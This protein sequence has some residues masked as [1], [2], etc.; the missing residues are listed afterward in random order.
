MIVRVM[1]MERMGGGGGCDV[2]FGLS[3]VEGLDTG[4]LGYLS[5]CTHLLACLV[6]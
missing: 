1:R 3:T 4:Y 6:N 5:V 2:L